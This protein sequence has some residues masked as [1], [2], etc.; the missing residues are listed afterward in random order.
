MA[1]TIVKNMEELKEVDRLRKDL[2]A[3]IS[4]DIRTPLSIIQGYVETLLIKEGTLETGTGAEYLQTIMK[5]TER[6]N[7]LVGGLFELT[8]L[9]SKQ[10]TP[11]ME[12][13][14]I[15][16][17]L[18][19]LVPKYKL[20]ARERGINISTE[21]AS[22]SPLIVSADLAMMERVLQNLIDNAINYSGADGIVKISAENVGSEVLLSVSNTGPNIPEQDLPKIFDRY[23]KVN[24]QG[25]GRGSGLG[26]AIVK[27]ILELHK[28]KI[29]AS[30]GLG[31]TIFSFKLPLQ[32]TFN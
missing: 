5:N 32:Q 12:T 21:L 3:N 7:R 11:K 23:Y 2:V 29:N 18:Q 30:S 1:D 31:L 14:F 28:I 26:L 20:L 22:E 17:L 13:F 8:Q 24:G 16:D 19:D 10:V 15:S 9:E 27:S 4:H 6:L 25:L